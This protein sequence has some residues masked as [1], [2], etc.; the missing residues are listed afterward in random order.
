VAAD[1]SVAAFLAALAC[2]CAHVAE[3]VDCWQ[4]Q[5]TSQP[6]L[7]ELQR[8][9]RARQERPADGR[10]CAAGDAAACF[11]VGE[12]DERHG[13][14]E[15]AAGAYA[16]ACDAGLARG[17]N[18]AGALSRRR[19]EAAARAVAWFD[20]ACGLG[21]AIGCY[22]AAQTTADPGARAA[23]FE[24]ACTLGSAIACAPGGEATAAANPARAERLLR[25]G[26]AR[27]SDDACAALGRLAV[28]GR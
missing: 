22:E 20:R 5:G 2:G 3:E 17:C 16:A 26:C 4:A 23:F 18:G 14:E 9:R 25:L 7:E 6:C 11:R 1:R 15:A 21:D 10:A 19:K 27:G 24:R 8:E 13:A 12:Y 28:G